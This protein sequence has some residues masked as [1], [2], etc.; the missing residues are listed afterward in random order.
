MRLDTDFPIAVQRDIR[1]TRITMLFVV[2]FYFLISW[3]LR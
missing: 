1:R 3:V 2:L